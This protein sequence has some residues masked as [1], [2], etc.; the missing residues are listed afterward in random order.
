MVVVCASF[1]IIPISSRLELELER[2]Y[3]C[4]SNGMDRYSIYLVG[5]R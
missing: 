5:S 2:V 4:W 3:M 1:S